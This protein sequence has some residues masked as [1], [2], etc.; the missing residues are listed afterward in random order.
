[1]VI[2]V[3]D[4]IY[5][6]SYHWF[7]ILL[8]NLWTIFCVFYY[9]DEYVIFHTCTFCISK[10][11]LTLTHL[12]FFSFYHYIIYILFF[13]R[14]NVPTICLFLAIFRPTYYKIHINQAGVLFISIVH[15]L[16]NYHC[17]LNYEWQWPILTMNT[18]N[19]H[20]HLL[21]IMTSIIRICG[22]WDYTCC[23]WR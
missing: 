8:L 10:F 23:M 12:F 20:T 14:L 11:I 21:F 22:D 18:N 2:L 17:I 3:I 5:C 13:C 1:M 16:C 6:V 9:C 19:P 7:Y 15:T 4:Y